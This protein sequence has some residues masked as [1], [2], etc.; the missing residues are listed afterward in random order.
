MVF[1]AGGVK[2]GNDNG[3]DDVATSESWISEGDSAIGQNRQNG[4]LCDVTCLSNIPVDALNRFRGE[5][6]VYV[7]DQTAQDAVK[8]RVG[9]LR[10]SKIG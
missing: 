10:G 8:D 4:V 3:Q 2:Y 1:V 5:V 7:W 9:I 6:T